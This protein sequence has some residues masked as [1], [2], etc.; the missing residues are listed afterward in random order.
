MDL[1]PAIDLRAGAAVRLTQGDY[2][3]ETQYGDPISLAQQFKEGGASWI[4]VVDLDAARTGKA[5]ESEVLRHIVGV[6]VP[7]ETGGGLRTE[8]DIEAVFAAGVHRA[9]LGTAAVEDPSFAIA[10]ARRWPNKIAVG[11]DYVVG[12]DGRSE[13]RAHG[14]LSGN[15][16]SPVELLERWESEPFAAVVATSI[17]RDGMLQGPDVTGLAELLDVTALPV[18]A[19]GGVGSL[20]DL[21]SLASLSGSHGPLSG[22]IVGKALVEGKFTVEEAVMACATSA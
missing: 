11:L 12:A 2:D 21:R 1:Y 20:D 15:G 13:A 5:H 17:D 18:I 8:E 4:H 9:I 22:A 19:S 16:T 6:G 3:R 7:V 14:W 10:C